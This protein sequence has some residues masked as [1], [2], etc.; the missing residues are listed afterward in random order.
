MASIPLA[1]LSIS[2]LLNIRKIK[3]FGKT[4]KVIECVIILESFSLE[5]Y[6]PSE[7][8]PDEKRNTNNSNN[9]W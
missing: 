3:I 8:S 6:E 9:K 1:A 4:H 7:I 2:N 5:R